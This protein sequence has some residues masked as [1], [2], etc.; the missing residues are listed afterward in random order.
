MFE[1]EDPKD[2]VQRHL[3][4]LSGQCLPGVY[5]HRKGGVYVVYG[6]TVDEAT[7]APLVHYY[8]VAK[9]TRWTRTVDNFIEE[10]DGR[11]RFVR[12]RDATL[13]ELLQARR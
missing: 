12:L 3:P 4:S 7:L 8:S 11:P 1:I 5:S 13:D 6:H 9:G 2:T 10:V